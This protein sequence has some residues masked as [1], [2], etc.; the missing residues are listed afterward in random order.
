MSTRGCGGL[1]FENI[2]LLIINTLTYGLLLDRFTRPPQFLRVEQDEPKTKRVNMGDARDVVFLGYAACISSSQGTRRAVTAEIR[3]DEGLH[4]SEGIESWWVEVS[5]QIDGLQLYSEVSVAS[6]DIKNEPEDGKD[7]LFL[8]LHTGLSCPQVR[9]EGGDGK[10]FDRHHDDT[11]AIK[12]KKS[13]LE[14]HIRNCVYNEILTCDKLDEDWMIER[15]NAWIE[16]MV[17][18]HKEKNQAKT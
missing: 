2:F 6:A 3:C 16:E 9:R 10:C 7:P 15:M 17:S 4:D 13:L 12:G 18:E 11:E 14:A 1:L 8:M 5:L